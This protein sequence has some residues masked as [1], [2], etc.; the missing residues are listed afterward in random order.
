M[1]G[2]LGPLVVGRQCDGP[3]AVVMGSGGTA[4][5]AVFGL[6]QLGVR[7]V[8]VVARNRDKAA[9]LVSLGE[10]LGLDVRWVDLGT[11][12]SGVDVV[13]NTLPADAAAEHVDS[14]AGVPVLLDVVY[15]PWP[16]PLAAA[17]SAAG[18]R[19]ISGLRMLLHQAFAQV[20]QFTGRPA[21]KEAMSAALD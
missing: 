7:H 15:D 5:A 14:V 3:L 13:V 2:A 8:T 19:V 9:P 21:P 4:P 16:T 12:L 20:E 6:A 17:V 18:G 1:I 11:P 10:R